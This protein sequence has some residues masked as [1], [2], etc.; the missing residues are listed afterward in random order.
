M[1]FELPNLVMTYIA[2]VKPWPIEIDGLPFSR[3]DGFS[4]ANCECHNQM[5]DVF[6][7]KYF[8]G[9]LVKSAHQGTL[10]FFSVF[11]CDGLKQ[12]L[13][14]NINDNRMLFSLFMSTQD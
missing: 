11:V 14:M 13:I 6:T 2:M 3:M 8:E 4:M 7:M 10:F 5:V 1:G 9:L 12:S